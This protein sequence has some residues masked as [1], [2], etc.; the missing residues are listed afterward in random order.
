[1]VRGSAEAQEVLDS[2]SLGGFNCRNSANR[3]ANP[4]SRADVLLLPNDLESFGLAALEG[5]ACGVPAG[6]SR[7]GV[8]E[9]IRDGV[10]GYLV[11]PRDVKTM[12]ARALDILTD[13]ERRARMGKAARERAL[14]QFCS[15]RIIPLY[16]QLYR[17]V[18]EKS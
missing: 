15:T 10:E 5:M 11:P 8:P 18:M 9:V 13:P 16:E 3:Q 6:C 4:Y 7:T 2:P 17:R 1:M 14:S 12:A